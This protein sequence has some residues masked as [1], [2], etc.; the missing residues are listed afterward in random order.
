MTLV[1][2]VAD[3]HG[4]ELA[5]A[6][7]MPGLRVELQFAR[8]VGALVRASDT[9]TVR[10]FPWR[11]SDAGNPVRLSCGLWRGFADPRPVRT[12]HRRLGGLGDIDWLGKDGLSANLGDRCQEPLPGCLSFWAGVHWKQQIRTFWP[13]SRYSAL[14]DKGERFNARH[15]GRGIFIVRFIPGVK[16]VVPTIAGVMGMSTTQFSLVNVGSARLGGGASSACYCFGAQGFRLRMPP[17]TRALPS[18]RAF[19]C[20]GAVLAWAALQLVRR[21]LVP[22]A[23]RG[24]LHWHF[25]WSSKVAAAAQWRASCEITTGCLKRRPGSG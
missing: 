10:G 9:F 15:G 22:A 23:D 5:L 4:A 21:V 25:G 13:F 1:K 18:S 3:L 20:D 17:P 6:D 14:M 7:A 8:I 24:R 2:A 11:A 19:R 12:F 16:A